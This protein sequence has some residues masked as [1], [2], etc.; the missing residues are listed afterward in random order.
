MCGGRGPRVS[1]TAPGTF[2]SHASCSLHLLKYTICGKWVTLLHLCESTGADPTG[3]SWSQAGSKPEPVRSASPCL[4]WPHHEQPEAPRLSNRQ[5]W[6]PHLICKSTHVV[7]LWLNWKSQ[8]LSSIKVM[9][10]IK[11]FTH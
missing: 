9:D 2:I 5:G 10:F 3:P 6:T 11:E 4:A 8:V 7:F 1:F